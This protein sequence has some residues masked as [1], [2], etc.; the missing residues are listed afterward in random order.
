MLVI[1]GHN[2]CCT[3]CDADDRYLSTGTE[4]FFFVRDRVKFRQLILDLHDDFSGHFTLSGDR[5]IHFTIHTERIADIHGSVR[6][7]FQHTPQSN[8][9]QEHSDKS[10]D[11]CK[12]RCAPDRHSRFHEDQAGPA[13]EAEEGN[14]ALHRKEPESGTMQF[15]CTIYISPSVR[16]ILIRDTYIR[17]SD[18]QVVRCGVR[19]VD[20]ATMDIYDYASLHLAEIVDQLTDMCIS[21]QIVIIIESDVAVRSGD[22]S[23]NRA[24]QIRSDVTVNAS[25]VTMTE[26]VSDVAV[27]MSEIVPDIH[28]MP[29]ITM[30]VSEIVPD[31]HV[32]PEITMS[33]SEIVPDI[34][35]MPVTEV[36]TMAAHIMT[37]QIACCM[38]RC[39]D[40][41]ENKLEDQKN[42]ED[43]RDAREDLLRQIQ[44]FKPIYKKFHCCSPFLDFS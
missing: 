8:C 40:Q 22:I 12:K 11:E 3:L 41:Q 6:L 15:V 43:N 7:C 25:D 42:G 1:F 35:V 13:E 37:V 31:I 9:H 5:D 18:H 34:H 26:T 27:S 29:E 10:A 24:V 4:L 21:V 28:V 38:R 32:M 16:Q 19:E 30:S 39:S 20:I 33:V 36:V 44:C 17:T 23:V 14:D 2:Q